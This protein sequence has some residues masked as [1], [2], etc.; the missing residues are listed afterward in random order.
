MIKALCWD[1][2]GLIFNT[3]E[4][5]RKSWEAAAERQGFSISDK[6]YRSFIGR[7]DWECEELL[8]AAHQTIAIDQFRQDRSTDFEHRLVSERQY[9]KGFDELI[10]TAHRNGLKQALV[11]SSV[12]ADVNRNFADS[13]YLELFDVVITA[14]SVKFGKPKPDCYQLA[15]QLLGVDP[16]QSMVLED[17]AN[18]IQAA[19]LAG[20]MPVMIP[21]MIPP[22]DGL[23]DK[24]TVLASL[25]MVHP[26]LF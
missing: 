12:L 9:K 19:L 1:M 10:R 23:T 14:E 21:D 7:Q 4:I 26:L 18:G 17:S 3:E 16:A 15:C 25:D 24:V 2:D 11:T 13:N 22:D 20:C 6:L 8:T 5:Y